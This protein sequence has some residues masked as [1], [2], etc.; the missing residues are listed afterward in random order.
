MPCEACAAIHFRP[1]KSHDFRQPQ[2][3]HVLHRNRQSFNKSLSEGCHLCLLISSQLDEYESDSDICDTL[4][5]YIVLLRSGN[6]TNTTRVGDIRSIRVASRLG[7]A[8]LDVIQPLPDLY[9]FLQ[10]GPDARSTNTSPSPQSTGRRPRKRRRLAVKK[11]TKTS[12]HDD[13]QD[14]STEVSTGS[15]TNLRLAQIWLNECRKQHPQCRIDTPVTTKTPLPTRL[16]N[17]EDINKPFLEEAGPNTKDPYIALSYTWGNNKRSLT[18]KS[19]YESYQ[20]CLPVDD[21][22]NTFADVIKVTKALD[23]KYVWIDAF[24]VIQD[25]SHDLER[26]LPKMGDIYRYAEF[27]IYAEGA[28]SSQSGLFFNRNPL[29]YRPCNISI[30]TT[31]DKG[32]VSEDL[33]VATTCNGPDYLK[34]RG[35]ILQER[36]LSARRLVFGQQMAW[37]CIAG[38]AQETKPVMRSRPPYPKS[39]VFGTLEKMRLTINATKTIV[40]AQKKQDRIECFDVW[41]EML[42]EY[43]N[44]ELTMASDNLRALS[45]LAP[46][47][48]EA[49]G[50]SYLAG[51]WKEDIQHGLAWYV[52]L[53]DERSVSKL[54]DGPSWSW[55]S[56]GKVRIQFRSW[57]G[58]SGCVVKSGAELRDA[59]CKLF[60][61]ANPFGA[62]GRG[63]L[64]MFAPLR[65]A[66][67]QHT[68]DFATRRIEQCYGGESAGFQGVDTREHPR[69]P[70]LLLDPATKQPL[71]EA[72]LDKPWAWL[73]SHEDP[74]ESPSTSAPERRVWCMLLHV[75]RFREGFRSALLVLEKSKA[76]PGMYCRIGLGFLC[77]DNSAWFGI[78]DEQG[79]SLEQWMT[80][81]PNEDEIYSLLV[82]SWADAFLPERALA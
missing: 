42:E 21:M 7:T 73:P 11:T 62:V 51:V 10:R 5:A 40:E 74:T 38:E 2:L 64:T 46:L 9:A 12:N 23:Y 47:F 53:N 80:M 68:S 50:A 24:C 52:C 28:Q 27:T 18:L 15:S 77:E 32:S 71:A 44:T 55:A 60:D 66:V 56:V 76:E 43:S 35:W 6:V 3:F 33:T 34:S 69:Y 58:A 78:Q 20:H 1:L 37:S 82:V 14:S 75:Q 29:T 61:T 70:A 63:L 54:T 72:A 57:R 4:Q 49:V 8:V 79:V 39:S 26:E 45:G 17:V 30:T 59:S 13:V 48:H 25:D 81:N 16:I 67:L 22:P 36:V 31:T 41:Y 19:N 65:E